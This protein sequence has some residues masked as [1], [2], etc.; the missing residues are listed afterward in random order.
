MYEFLCGK[1]CVKQVEGRWVVRVRCPR[2]PTEEELESLRE[3]LEEG[4]LKPSVLAAVALAGR[5]L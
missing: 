5:R 1:Q 3:G 2:L 4:R